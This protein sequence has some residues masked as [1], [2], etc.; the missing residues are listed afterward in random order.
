MNKIK[1]NLRNVHYAVIDSIDSDGLPKYKT[2]VPIPGAVSLSLAAQGDSSDFF[3]D[4][5]KY[6]VTTTNNGYSGDITLALIPDH[7]R[8]SVL[9]EELDSTDKILTETAFAKEVQFALLYQFDG[10]K[11][12]IKHV[13]YNC[14]ATR[15]GLDGTTATNSKEPTTE[16]LTLISTP[17]SNGWVK[18][19][20][21]TD[22][23]AAIDDNWFKTIT[24]PLGE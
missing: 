19:K 7:F 3:A 6:Y 23:P 5:I 22:T 1:Y 18:S 24:F 21:T 14:T 12:A 10:D 4:G 8:I 13:M 11:K 20:T 16:T 15:P 17:L 2:P 9:G